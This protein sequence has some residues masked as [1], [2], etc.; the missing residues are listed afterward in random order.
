MLN[1]PTCD[2][3]PLEDEIRLRSEFV[4]VLFDLSTNVHAARVVVAEIVDAGQLAFVFDRYCGVV[5]EVD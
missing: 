4:H 5:Q 2:R 1:L 3:Y